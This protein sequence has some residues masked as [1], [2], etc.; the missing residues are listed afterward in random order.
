MAAVPAGQRLAPKTEGG[1]L[2]AV[3]DRE[4]LFSRKDLPRL[5][6]MLAGGMAAAVL[7]R[8]FDDAAVEGLLRLNRSSQPDELA[9][10]MEQALSPRRQG[11]WHMLAAEQAR[12][13]AE[14]HWGRLRGMSPKGW[15]PA[16][17]FIGE[18]RVR[19]A[20]Q[21]GRG[22]VMWCMRF[23]SDI[24]LKQGFHG[25][26]LPLVHLS[27]AA[28]GA[29]GSRT[30]LATRIIS[31]LFRRAEDNYLAG[32]VIIP[33]GESLGYLKTLRDHL[34]KNA[35]VSIFGDATGRQAI[36]VPFLSGL[37]G[38]AT[39]APSI[40]WAENCPLFPVYVVRSGRWK[41]RVFVDEPIPVDRSVPRKEFVKNAVT[42][43]AHR[44]EQLVERYPADWQDW[45]VWK[46]KTT[47]R[48]QTR[49]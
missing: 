22:A 5:A 11:D 19:D 35:C 28:H 30:K 49:A 18:Q 27:A 40:A 3:T 2:T 21:A 47:A 1:L 43:F 29:L 37:C 34:Q 17:E 9:A 38:F 12:M 7:P 6:K 4:K 26:G 14:D 15:S 42:E 20:L 44:V 41:Y 16:I 25:V 39:G 10:T 33:L 45:S 31:P 36:E 46:A 48:P 13:L 8:S 32:R 24:A 23:S